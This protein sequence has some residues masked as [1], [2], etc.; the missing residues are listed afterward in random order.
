MLGFALGVD[1]CQAIGQNIE[2]LSEWGV[3]D[4]IYIALISIACLCISISLCVL[5]GLHTYLA[6]AALSSWEY[7]SWKRITYLKVWPRKYGSPFGLGS[8]QANLVEFFK[9]KPTKFAHQWRMPSRL[10]TL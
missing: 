4:E 2:Q 7:F 6:T 5:I 1:V 3:A 10:P 8:R 9:F